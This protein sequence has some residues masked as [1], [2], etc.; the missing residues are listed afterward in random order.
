M[1]IDKD[2]KV[3]VG[4]LVDYKPGVFGTTT[5]LIE[6]YGKEESKTFQ[7]QKFNDFYV[8]WNGM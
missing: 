8:N 2:V 5:G 4:Q 3:K 1:K 6:K 7:L